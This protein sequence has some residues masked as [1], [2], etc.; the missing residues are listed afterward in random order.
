MRITARSA[1]A[2]PVPADGQALYFDDEVKG[3]GVRVTSTG[4]RSYIVEVRR[5]SRS[6]RITVGRVPE[7][8]VAEARSLAIGMKRGGIG[9]RER[10]RA[11][12]A[13]A[14]HRYGVDRRGAL[15][16]STWRRVTCLWL[17]CRVADAMCPTRWSAVVTSEILKR[18]LQYSQSRQWLAPQHL[19]R[20]AAS[21]P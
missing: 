10:Y 4:S 13:D 12:F 14:W 21:G 11:T 17:F 6:Q 9:K 15:S 2:A 16:A 18:L 19:P 1:K 20:W 8:T 5:G 7:L 3:F